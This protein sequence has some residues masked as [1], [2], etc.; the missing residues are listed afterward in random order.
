MNALAEIVFD[1]QDRGQYKSPP[2]PTPPYL[3]PLVVA[4]IKCVDAIY[5]WPQARDLG[6]FGRFIGE[7][8]TRRLMRF[9]PVA[10]PFVT[11]HPEYSLLIDYRGPNI[12]EAVTWICKDLE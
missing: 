6:M 11:F 9:L 5:E 2:R 8:M 10:L 7:T 3:D 4:Y 12:N 1:L